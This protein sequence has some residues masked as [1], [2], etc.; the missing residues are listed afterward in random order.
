[1]A[2]ISKDG[3]CDWKNGH[4][5]QLVSQHMIKKNNHG[6]MRDAKR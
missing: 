1:M 6:D 3:K 2:H 5:N 4:A